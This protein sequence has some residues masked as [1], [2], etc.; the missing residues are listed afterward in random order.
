MLKK[1]AGGVGG[2]RDEEAKP[3]LIF[4]NTVRGCY[5]GRWTEHHLNVFVAKLRSCQTLTWM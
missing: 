1:C 2:K 5:K 3:N 4:F